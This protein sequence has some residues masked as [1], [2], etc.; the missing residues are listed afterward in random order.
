MRILAGAASLALVLAACGGD[1]STDTADKAAT[2]EKPDSTAES[3]TSS[4]LEGRVIDEVDI[5]PDDFSDPTTLTN[6]FMPASE[7]SYLIMLGEDEGEP[8]RIEVTP[9]ADAKTIEWNEGTTDA[10]VSQ[11]L[12][13]SD[14]ELL[15]IADDFFAQDDAGNVWYF[16]EDVFNYDAGRLDDTEGSWLAGRDGPPGMI[17]PADPQVDDIFHPENIPDLVFEEDIVRSVD[18]TVEGPAGPIAGSLEIE[19]H[20]EGEIELKYWAPGYGEFRALTEGVEDVIVVFALPNDAEAEALPSSLSELQTAAT[21]AFDLAQDEDWNA[22][23]T[24][25]D[26]MATDWEA[27]DPASR[28]VLPEQFVEAVDATLDELTT[29]VE[30]EDAAGAAEAAVAL[31][32]AVLD[33]VMTHGSL[34][35][36]DRIVALSHQLTL[37]AGE[38][39]AASAANTVAIASAVWARSASTVDDPAGIDAI[40]TSL[41]AAAE[42]DDFAALESGATDLIEAAASAA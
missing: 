1:D 31:D 2:T 3:T 10:L 19:E 11:F 27:Y 26:G 16:G 35:D 17:M 8:L 15:E 23:S 21:G 36:L 30:D 40:V 28:D 38:E 29:A 25:L 13:S 4:S 34:P 9:L 41:E 37:A 6:R 7:V 22:L 39:D 12:E 5:G 32:L 42:D 24:S 33:V 14:G 18:A 20:H